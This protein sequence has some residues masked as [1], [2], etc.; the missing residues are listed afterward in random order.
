ML[1]ERCATWEDLEENHHLEEVGEPIWH[2]TVG[3]THCPFC[4]QF[5]P[6]EMPPSGEAR[7]AESYHID[8]SGWVGKYQ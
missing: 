4:G 1:I 8:A 3:I 7:Q 6:D 5:L 2:I